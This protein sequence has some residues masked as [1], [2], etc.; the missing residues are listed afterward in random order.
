MFDTMKVARKIKEARIARN[1][2]QMNLADAMEV[3][4]QAVSNW[5]RGSS[6]PDIGKLEQLCQIL[7]I[8]VDEL[9]G[10]DSASRTLSRIIE[11]EEPS[12]AY[13]EPVTI[14]E[15]QEVAPLLPPAD[16]AWLVDDSLDNQEDGEK[17]DLKAIAGLAPF[18]DEKYLDALIKRAHVHS[19]KDLAGLAPFLSSET[20]DVL[21]AEADIKGDISG[22]ISLAP[23]LGSETLDALVDK[24]EEKGDIREVRGLAPFL[25]SGTLDRLVQKMLPL[26]D[27]EGIRGLAPFLS[28]DALGALIENADPRQ[29]M[30][31]IVALAPFL[32][33][34]ALARFL[35]KLPDDAHVDIS[36]LYPFLPQK[37][38][39]K[40]AES[41]MRGGDLHA[42]KSLAPFL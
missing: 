6:C 15:I 12:K 17:L 10:T 38:L 35:E 16:M 28:S 32:G 42:L 39:Q 4:Y 36:G 33:E 13:A 20:L 21:V 5:E 14:E 23:F 40:M 9:L 27:W 31:H 24:M 11:K 1:M 22:I 29:D 19:L 41:L 37:T 8:G 3:S 26:D 25:S 34:E 30:S 18:L 2:T 7:E